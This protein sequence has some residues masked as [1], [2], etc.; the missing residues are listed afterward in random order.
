M[1]I[2]IIIVPRDLYVGYIKASKTGKLSTTLLTKMK[3]E[4]DKPIT[5][6]A[7]AGWELSDEG[8]KYPEFF[9]SY[10][11]NL[12]KQLWAKVEVTIK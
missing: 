12:V 9:K 4:N 3:I 8:F 5:Y 11:E 10:V 7:A 6:Y 2:I 1:V